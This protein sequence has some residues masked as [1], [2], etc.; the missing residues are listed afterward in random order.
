MPKCERCGRI[1]QLYKNWRTDPVTG[2]KQEWWLCWDCDWEMMNN[3]VPENEE[4]WEI[5]QRRREEEYE[6]DP[7]NNDPPW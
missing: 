6:Y 1:D 3:W 7:I 2:K 4:E 5:E